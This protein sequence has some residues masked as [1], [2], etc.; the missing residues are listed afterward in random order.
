MTMA[1]LS[2]RMK[3]VKEYTQ[4]LQNYKMET[5]MQA[6]D[7]Y[8]NTDQFK[9]AVASMPSDA[10]NQLARAA[11]EAVTNPAAD[12]LDTLRA[13]GFRS[14]E[15]RNIVHKLYSTYCTAIDGNHLNDEDMVYEDMLPI[16]A[17]YV[18]AHQE[19]YSTLNVEELR[20]R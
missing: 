2:E 18:T 14:G 6:I 15:I 4:K 17:E 20:E 12:F 1:G 5:A 9:L 3:H 8:M 13:K 19:I 16:V 7:S 10:A 11:V